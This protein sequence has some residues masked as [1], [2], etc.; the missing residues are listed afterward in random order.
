MGRGP[1]FRV[2]RDRRPVVVAVAGPNGAGKSTFIE[3][4]LARP[5]RLVARYA[6]GKREVV[7]PPLPVW[8]P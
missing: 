4:H 3:A 5:F 8:L 7:N 1:D 6:D 2:A